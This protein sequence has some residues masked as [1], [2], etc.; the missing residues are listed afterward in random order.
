LG[1]SVNPY[2][3]FNNNYSSLFPT[4]FLNYKIDSLGTKNL[5]F[6]YGRR[7]DRP[8]YKDLNPFSSP[9]DQYTIYEGNPFLK[10]TFSHNFNLIYSY[11]DWF[12]T[13]LSYAFTNDDISETIEIKNGI[14][15]SRPNNIG[16]SKLYNLSF[17]TRNKP[18]NWL[19]SNVY[20]EFNYSEYKSLL[21][22]Q[23]LHSKGFT[24]NINVVNSIQFSKDWIGEVKGEYT[25]DF[26]S[27]QLKFGD[28]GHLSVGVLKKLWND[29]ATIKL[30]LS[31]IFHTNRIRGTINNLENTEANWYGPRDTRVASVTFSYRFGSGTGNKKKYEG[32]GSETEQNRIKS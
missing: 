3:E 4:V 8:F 6:S 10:P 18:F 31:D 1:N 13:T 7:V 24:W 23:N 29:K 17:Q 2:S 21:Y 22:N 28:F 9:L 11:K 26:I 14:Y 30:N 32:T 27:A 19:T 16:K 15:Y 25:S 20:T 12:S 5:N